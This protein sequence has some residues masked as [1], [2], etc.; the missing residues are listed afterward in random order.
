MWLE[1]QKVIRTWRKILHIIGRHI[2]SCGWPELY[3]N[4]HSKTTLYHAFNCIT[5]DSG[6]KYFFKNEK[7]ISIRT[8]H[9]I[10]YTQLPIH[11]SPYSELTISLNGVTLH[12]IINPEAQ[13]QT[14]TE[15]YFGYKQNEKSNES[16]IPDGK[17]RN[18]TIEE[19]ISGLIYLC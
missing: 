18:F 13:E 3:I 5:D 9:R 8:W 10:E 14:D 12:R 4:E 7:D 1:E 15:V 19:I 2:S 11:N 6:K 17:I 16:T